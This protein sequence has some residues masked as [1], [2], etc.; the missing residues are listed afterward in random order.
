MAIELTKEEVADVIPS[1]RRYFKEE[2]EL[3]ISEMRA[4]FLLSYFL[5]EIAP[6][7]Y[8]K[9]VKDAETYFRG[10]VEDLSGT[11]FE[12]ALT[13]WLKKKK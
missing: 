8:N 13:Y 2:L 6:F 10:R 1:L 9:G 4:K 5:K 3:E 7:A 12:P 11:C